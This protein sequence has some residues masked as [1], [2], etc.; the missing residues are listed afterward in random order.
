MQNGA[1]LARGPQWL[2]GAARESEFGPGAAER[3]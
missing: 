3:I 1:A 2:A